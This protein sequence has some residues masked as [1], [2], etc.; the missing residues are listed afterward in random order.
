VR[1]ITGVRLGLTFAPVLEPGDE[2]RALLVP[3][4][5]FDIEDGGLASAA[6]SGSIVPVLAVEDEFLPKPV[7]EPTPGATEPAP[8][9]EPEPP[10]SVPG[11][12]EPAVEDDEIS[13]V[14][15]D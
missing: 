4:F 11:A 13:G 6:G 14:T 9:P 12:T 1:T 2:G 7:E 10:Q 8:A 15:S 5:L 3:V